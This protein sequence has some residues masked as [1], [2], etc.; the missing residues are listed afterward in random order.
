MLSHFQPYLFGDSK[1]WMIGKFWSYINA[2]LRTCLKCSCWTAKIFS[3]WAWSR[4]CKYIPRSFT[5][6]SLVKSYNIH[7]KSFKFGNNLQRSNKTF[8]N[9]LP[10][11]LK[12]DKEQ[13]VALYF[14]PSSKRTS[15]VTTNEDSEFSGCRKIFWNKYT[16]NFLKYRNF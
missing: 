8:G 4:E 2:M 3:Y 6:F 15:Y 11:S 14:G 5:C 1:F 16:I 7:T 13:F 9:N 12:L 10:W